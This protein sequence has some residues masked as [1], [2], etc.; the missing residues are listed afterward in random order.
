MCVRGGGGDLVSDIELEL[1][2]SSMGNKPS[3]ITHDISIIF[4]C[5]FLLDKLILLKIITPGDTLNK[6]ET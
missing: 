3:L 4:F 5:L 2:N 6:S 1:S